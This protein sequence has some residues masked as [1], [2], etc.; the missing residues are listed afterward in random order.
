MKILLTRLDEWKGFINDT[1]QLLP[2]PNLSFTYILMFIIFVSIV[3]IFLD[4]HGFFFHTN[5][6]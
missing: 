3:V 2:S 4:I 1:K 6:L 5:D